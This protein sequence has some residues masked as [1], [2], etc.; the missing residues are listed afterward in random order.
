MVVVVLV[1][2]VVVVVAAVVVVVGVVAVAVVVA[3]VIVAVVGGG[4]S[5]SSRSGST[6]GS[7]VEWLLRMNTITM[8]TKRVEVRVVSQLTHCVSILL[9]SLYK[10]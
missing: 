3:V 6:V 9:I 7:I 4:R 2:V 5:S 10:H 8:R 1:V